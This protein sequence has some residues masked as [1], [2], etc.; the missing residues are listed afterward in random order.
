[1]I[2]EQPVSQIG[3]QCYTCLR[4]RSCHESG[5]RLASIG[6]GLRISHTHAA[7]PVCFSETR[8]L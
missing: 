2:N 6:F 1:M 3:G 8:D 7:D 4:L 5:F